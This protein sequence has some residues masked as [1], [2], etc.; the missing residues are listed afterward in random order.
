VSARLNLVVVLATLSCTFACSGRGEPP[1]ARTDLAEQRHLFTELADSLGDGQRRVIAAF[2]PADA[3]AMAFT[4]TTSGIS[5]RADALTQRDLIDARTA[6]FVRVAQ[7]DSS[8]A[9]VVYY[10]PRSLA[11][12]P[13]EAGEDIA[14]DGNRVQLVR[15]IPRDV[16]PG[17]ETFTIMRAD[18]SIDQDNRVHAERA[19]TLAEGNGSGVA[20]IIARDEVYFSAGKKL[21]RLLHVAGTGGKAEPVWS[22][23][24]DEQIFPR[25]SADG[26]L[27]FAANGEGRFRWYSWNFSG[28]PLPYTAS[29]M[30]KRAA[31]LRMTCEIRDGALRPIIVAE[32]ERYDFAALMA[33]VEASAPSINR[34]RALLSAALIEARQSTLAHLPT[35]SWQFLMT[36]A[37]G[38]FIDPSGV[39]SG[40]MLAEHIARGVFGLVQPLFDWKRV[41]AASSAAL[42]RARI[43]GDALA[44]EVD[45]T[46][47]EAAEHYLSVMEAR[48]R[49]SADR[50]AVAVHEQAR[51]YRRNLADGGGGEAELLAAERL[52]TQAQARLAADADDEHY[53][54][55][56]LRAA[57]GIERGARFELTD[58]ALSQLP[59]AIS[60]ADAL[61]AAALNSPRLRAARATV[62][63]AFW[64]SRAGSRYAPT[65]SLGAYYGQSRRNG[66][67]PV[68]DY[69]TL[70]LGG[71]LPLAY[72]KDRKLQAERSRRLAESLS[73][74]EAESREA[75]AD[76]CH[77]AWLEYRA[78][79]AAVDDGMLAA[80]HD[81]E[82]LRVARLAAASAP[83]D[84]D[85]PS[86]L[87]RLHSVR[88]AY[89]RARSDQL[90]M[91][92]GAARAYVRLQRCMAVSGKIA[93]EFSALD[94]DAR[95]TRSTWLWKSRE[96]L[97]D[98]TEIDRFIAIA[99]AHGISRC[100]CY[101]GGGLLSD[102][103]S[104]E[105]M[106]LFIQR[107]ARHDIAVWALIGEPEWLTSDSDA[108]LSSAV[109][110][111][112][113]FNSRAPLEPGLRGLKLDIEPQTLPDWTDET[114]RPALLA[115]W[116]ALSKTSTMSKTLA[117]SKTTRTAPGS[118]PVHADIPVAFLDLGEAD[119]LLE[120]LDGI[121][122]MNYIPDRQRALTVARHAL[123]WSSVPVE[124]GIE[125]SAES[126]ALALALV[127]ALRNHP[128][129]AGVA[130]HDA[131]SLSTSVIQEGTK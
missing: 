99:A 129:F 27:V 41:E 131:Q 96:T 12:V 117:M 91:R 28:A 64:V 47:A 57:C 94:R 38:V 19:V 55:Q 66:T 8:P 26:A 62:D 25:R 34:R 61:N 71:Q 46:L 16:R 13:L 76:D 56:R 44:D 39:S 54:L 40:D 112:V 80:A 2:A 110:A 21:R 86:A 52:L 7:S 105:R 35:F 77:R 81:L 74:A 22:E 69:I 18:F 87:D 58:D 109:T 84:S 104:A 101:C 51:D 126:D 37:I 115:R 17:R 130:L 1:S 89:A 75:V 124:I 3:Q 122:L 32:P 98:S 60:L 125:A 85:Q 92:F 63:E 116:R 107:C 23:R 67:A 43:A 106:A 24:T 78:A 20:P 48:A 102:D 29:A 70:S 100:Y 36:P 108:E 4:L 14:R 128:R 30:A 120:G 50:D 97:A 111:V 88:T 11:L 73:A 9:A 113:G 95:S 6:V 65:A 127:E 123:D 5:E 114:K 119:E 45:R 72:L 118:L 49:S 90:R 83:R 31:P 79:R 33:L 93:K 42:L 121:T 82:Q 15:S 68:D 59:P 10:D 103:A 53:H